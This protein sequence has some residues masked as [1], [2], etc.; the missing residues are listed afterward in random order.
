MFVEMK[1][2]GWPTNPKPDN[3]FNVHSR[4]A[5]NQKDFS[6][7]FTAPPGEQK[8]WK[9]DRY[10]SKLHTNRN[11]LLAALRQKYGKEAFAWQGGDTTTNVRSDNQITAM[12]WLFDEQGNHVPMPAS[13]VFPTRQSFEECTIVNHTD[14]PDMKTDADFANRLNPWCAAHFVAV[15]VQLSNLDIVENTYTYMMDIPLAART[16]RAGDAWL[17]DYANKVHQQDLQRSKE[18]TPTL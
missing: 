11:T 8:V 1:D 15:I 10:T 7:S 16:A 3:G 14:E 4:A 17:R 13:T 6:M 2:N 5:G 12:L 9:V 18:N